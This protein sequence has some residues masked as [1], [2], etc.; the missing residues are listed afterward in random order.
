MVVATLLAICFLFMLLGWTS[1]ED[2]FVALT[3]AA[4][5]GIAA[6]N[7]GTTAQDLKTAYLVG[8]TPYRQQ[9]ALFVGVLSSALLIGLT[10]V[11][12]NAGGTMRIPEKHPGKRLSELREE[13][14]VLHEIPFQLHPQH[15]ALQ[16]PLEKALWNE[17]GLSFDNHNLRG[18]REVHLESLAQTVLGLGGT[19]YVLGELGQWGQARQRPL[20]VGYAR[21]VPG[22]PDGKYLASEAGDI[23]YVVDPGIG[24]R[25]HEYLGQKFTRYDAP[26]ARL[27]ALIIDGILNQQLPWT[28]V[29]IGI[30]I[31]LML[32]LCGVPSLPFAVGVYLPISTSA[33][34]FVG[35][36]VRW[37][38]DK[39]RR[40]KNNAE[41]SSGTFLASGY[42]A[43]GAI[44]GVVVALLN[45]PQDGAWLKQLNLPAQ[46]GGLLEKLSPANG[47]TT[48]PSALWALF[49]F[50]L[51]VALLAKTASRPNSDTHSKTSNS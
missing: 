7:G 31:A 6:S 10:L 42:I 39:W 24:G 46:W 21:K 22:L 18:F 14:V 4:I 13:K 29:L 43:G 32:E 16:A 8:G 41:F 35:G 37:A 25:I 48:L 3:A 15:S 33:P 12:L 9:L 30:F 5:V 44:A 19:T 36:L 34:I 17:L 50:A 38:T 47:L 28:L 49:V 2:R 1:T 23:E 11:T 20:S 40:E 51:L 45:I 27:F 26:K